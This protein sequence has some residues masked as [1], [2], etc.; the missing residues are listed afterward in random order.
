MDLD[1]AGTANTIS[2][3]SLEVQEIEQPWFDDDWG[4]TNIQQAIVKRK[5]LNE[6]TTKF[7]NPKNGEG[8]LVISNEDAKNAWG[9]PRAV[10]I[11]F[12]FF[13]KSKTYFGLITV[14][15]SRR[16]L[17]YPSHEPQQQADPQECAVGQGS[18]LRNPRQGLG[19]VLVRFVLFYRIANFSS[20]STLWPTLRH[21]DLAA[22][23][24]LQFVGVEHELTRQAS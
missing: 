5:H 19:A 18:R 16:G 6:S 17:E 20:R 22:D 1:V 8:L 9:A 11:T 24:G 2:S 21:L 14:R 15:Y 4:T 3:V 7:E 10:Y 23:H 13:L 12:F